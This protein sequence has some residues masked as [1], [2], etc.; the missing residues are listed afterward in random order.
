MRRAD[1]TTKR[2][3]EILGITHI[4]INAGSR[5]KVDKLTELLEHDGYTIVSR[6]RV[7]GDGYYESSI[8]DPENNVVEI[9]CR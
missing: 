8:L 3:G 1:I 9:M 5:E 2:T 7:T 4:A 6:P